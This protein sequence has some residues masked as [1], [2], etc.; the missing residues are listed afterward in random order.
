MPKEKQT[1]DNIVEEALSD[2]KKIQKISVE[3]VRK[4]LE[5]SFMPR[6]KEMLQKELEEPEDDESVATDDSVEDMVPNADELP[7]ED[8]TQMEEP[9]IPD[10]E[11]SIEEDD[12]DSDPEDDL[13]DDE[14][15]DSDIEFDEE[16]ME[17]E[18]EP[19]SDEDDDE[20]IEI[21]EDE[22]ED[23]EEP[24]EDM[25]DDDDEEITEDFE[26]GSTEE[27]TSETVYDDDLPSS[28]DTDI[29]EENFKLQN[30][31]NKL[32]KANKKL[33]EQLYRISKSLKN[34]LVL[35]EQSRA[36]QDIFSK[37]SLTKEMKRAIVEQ[38]D[39]ARTVNS[40]KLVSESINK[41]LSTMKTQTKKID[42]GSASKIVKVV[43]DPNENKEVIKE[44]KEHVDG[45]VIEGTDMN[46]NPNRIALWQKLSKIK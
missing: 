11:Q 44:Q 23:S 3:R 26:E 34:A 41:T 20:V 29:V 17:D 8:G 18:P 27:P 39:K 7:A 40:I 24:D 14:M 25:E 4:Q 46:I 30:R 10:E 36:V 33:N 37:Y 22:D 13:G 6:M 5:E 28:Y 2:V 9:I 15:S 38:I 32:A 35:N 19:D 21:I 43:K 12:L 31:V 1:T 16:D 42:K 45:V